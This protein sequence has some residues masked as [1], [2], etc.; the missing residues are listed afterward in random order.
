[1]P[2]LITGRSR[3]F[4]RRDVLAAAL[5]HYRTVFAASDGKV[6]ATFDIVYLTGRAPRSPRQ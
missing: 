5:A 4:L 1:M 2:G 6:K 3:K